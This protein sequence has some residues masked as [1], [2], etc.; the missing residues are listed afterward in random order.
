M[1]LKLFADYFRSSVRTRALSKLGSPELSSP[2]PKTA[3]TAPPTATAKRKRNESDS[4]NHSVEE[5]RKRPRKGSG[6]GKKL[7]IHFVYEILYFTG[8]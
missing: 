3:K 5:M 7:V 1:Y 8:N 4:S 2:V 6:K